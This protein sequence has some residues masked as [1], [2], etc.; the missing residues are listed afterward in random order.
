MDFSPLIKLN[1]ACHKLHCKTTTSHLNP[2]IPGIQS[3]F[4]LKSQ[5]E[6]KFGCVDALYYIKKKL[7][8]YDTP[9]LRYIRF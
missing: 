7:L 2:T 4:K 3:N 1:R 5:Q 9:L 8:G 6:W